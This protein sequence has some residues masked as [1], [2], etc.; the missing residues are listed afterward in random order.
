MAGHEVVELVTQTGNNVTNLQ[1][2]DRVGLGQLNVLLSRAAQKHSA[3]MAYQD[4]FNH[5]GADGS[6][7]FDRIIN[8]GYRY[9]AAE[10]IAAGQS[11]PEAVLRS[12]M[13]SPGHRA[14]F[15]V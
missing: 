14:N 13:N 6:S 3:S 12:W 11:T 1:P 4:F 9:S 2:G 7:P 15:Q 10:N 5:T 8:E